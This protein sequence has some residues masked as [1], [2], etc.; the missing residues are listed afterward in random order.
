MGLL[1]DALAL[2]DEALTQDPGCREA[3]L[4]TA[5]ALLARGDLARGWAMHD[6]RFDLPAGGV[7]RRHVRVPR[8]RGE[9]LAGGSLVVWGEQGIGDEILF[10]SMYPELPASD[11]EVV[12]ECHAKLRALFQRSF[13]G[14]RVL[15]REER[16]ADMRPEPAFDFQIASGSLGSVLR[17]DSAHFPARRAYLV[18]DASRAAHWRKRLAASAP[19]LKVGFCWR[20]SNIEGERALSCTQLADWRRLFAMA[21][22][23]WISL[24][25][26]EC[27]DEL[28]QAMIRDP[29]RILHFDEVDYRDDLDEVSALIA[30]LD[31]VISAPTT[32][33][34]HA[35]ALGIETWQ[36]SFGADWQTLGTGGNPWLPAMRRYPRAWTERWDSVFARI[37]GDLAAVAERRRGPLAVERPC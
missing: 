30:G 1:Q 14:C 34:I 24:Q 31:L 5:H 13:P 35:A 21:G 19:G 17:A 25:Y 18:A 32:V 23:H 27:L 3:Q 22:V 7:K 9:S 26:D 2:Y 12:I 6:V 33:S 28:Q 8:W 20:S 29:N 16:S 10:A 4:N 15:D 11:G 36:F 37:A